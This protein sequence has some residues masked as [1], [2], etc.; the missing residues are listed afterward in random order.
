MPLNTHAMARVREA[1]AA[2]EVFLRVQEFPQEFPLVPPIAVPVVG[3]L[4]R[5]NPLGPRQPARP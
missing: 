4:G 2:P 5:V 1:G 3:K